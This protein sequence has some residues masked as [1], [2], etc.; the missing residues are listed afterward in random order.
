VS[1]RRVQVVPSLGS[2]SR[3]NR[4]IL[5]EVDWPW[6]ASCIGGGDSV[7]SRDRPRL[8]RSHVARPRSGRICPSTGASD[9]T[10]SSQVGGRRPGR[11]AA[12]HHGGAHALHGLPAVGYVT[13]RLDA[14]ADECA[15]ST[16][17]QNRPT[18]RTQPERVT[19][20]NG[21]VPGVRVEVDAP[22][23]PDGILRQEPPRGGIIPP[24]PQV[25][26]PTRLVRG[27]G[28]REARLRVRRRT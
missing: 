20:L 6:T 27:A 13:E 25:R 21:I 1:G 4:G 2:A 11:E 15:D 8:L 23:E 28:P 26:K 19:E 18:L 14:T 22:R 24:V 10:A 12:H 16:S 7:S 9:S 17:Y 3:W 5:S